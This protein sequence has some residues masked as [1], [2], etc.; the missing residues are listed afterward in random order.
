MFRRNKK[1]TLATEPTIYPDGVC[2]E[3]ETGYFL[4]RNQKRYRVPTQ[5]ILD[6]WS[7]PLIVQTTDRAVAR[8]KV[9]AKLGFRDGSLI[10]NFADGRI[11][12][13]SNNKRRW[14]KSPEALERLGVER[15]SAR[16][17]SDYEVN[18]QELGE[19]LV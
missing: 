14:I 5:K 9:V 7:F 19:D 8:Y 4:L 13:I 2:L 3:T 17:V 10:Y 11:Y 18:L 6:S 1:K 15:D 12:L 16:I